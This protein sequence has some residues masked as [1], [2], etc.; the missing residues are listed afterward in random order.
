MHGHIDAGSTIV[1]TIVAFL[2]QPQ[3]HIPI[4]RLTGIVENGDTALHLIA[5]DHT[6]RTVAYLMGS[7]LQVGTRR[8]TVGSNLHGALPYYIIT[9]IIANYEEGIQQ[10]Y[11]KARVDMYTGEA[12]AY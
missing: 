10:E 3:P 6:I 1:H 7:I 8:L 2:K 4:E 12:E 11:A 9:L 5:I